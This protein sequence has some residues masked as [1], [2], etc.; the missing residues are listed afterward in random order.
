MRLAICGLGM[1]G[2]AHLGHTLRIEGVELAA[3]CD[4]DPGRLDLSAEI[5]GNIEFGH[6][7]LRPEHVRRYD[8]FGALL[9]DAELDAVVIATPTESHAPMA[10]AALQAGLHVFCEKPIALTLD[11][12]DRMIE[13]AART[14]RVLMIGHVVRFFPAYVRIRGRIR[15]GEHGRVLGAEFSRICGLP[16]WGGQSWFRDPAR[17]GGMPIDL[18]IHDADFV[19]YALGAPRAVRSFRTHD[20]ATGIDLLR[21][22]YLFED[23]TV[24]SHGAWLHGSVAFSAWA[25]LIF[26][27]AGLYWHTDSSEHV[28]LHPSEGNRQRIELPAVDGYEAELR[29]FVESVHAGRPSEVVPPRSAREALRLVLLENESARLGRELEL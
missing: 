19:L 22:L 10:V 24:T 15:S 11:D 5:V 17:S 28:R 25:S 7:D 12:A 23:A 6:R 3:V 14:G 29:D 26:E 9:D 18:H 27:R 21:T 4:A 1:M 20:S 13:A 8:D 2:R 16:G